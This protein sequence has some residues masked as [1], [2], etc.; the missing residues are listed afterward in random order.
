MPADL[1]RFPDPDPRTGLPIPL[2]TSFAIT[3]FLQ[4]RISLG[5]QYY[6]IPSTVEFDR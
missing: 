5:G 3:W 6:R 4:Y 2:G 1:H